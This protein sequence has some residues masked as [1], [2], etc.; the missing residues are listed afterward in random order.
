MNKIL[1][2]SDIKSDSVGGDNIFSSSNLPNEEL[3][4]LTIN[5]IAGS[6]P[7]KVLFSYDEAGE[8]LNVGSRFISRRVQSGSIKVIYF[9][10]K[11]MIHITELARISLQG[12]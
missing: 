3:L 10:D 7:G 4:K 9:G 2:I 5:I 11:P 6:N 12:V 1:N 8:K